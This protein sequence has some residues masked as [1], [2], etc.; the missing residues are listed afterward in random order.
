[1][2]STKHLIGYFSDLKAPKGVNLLTIDRTILEDSLT[3][4]KYFTN[5][6]ITTLRE[7]F[8]IIIQKKEQEDEQ[9]QE[10]EQE[11][12]DEDKE[13]EK[14]KF[15]ESK[16]KS[17]HKQEKQ[18]SLEIQNNYFQNEEGQEE[19]NKKIPLPNQLVIKLSIS[20]EER[21]NIITQ[22]TQQLYLYLTT[23]SISNSSFSV[24]KQ[25][26]IFL[27]KLLYL[28]NNSKNL[29]QFR[30]KFFGE[31]YQENVSIIEHVILVSKKLDPK[32]KRYQSRRQIKRFEQYLYY[33]EKLMLQA[34]SILMQLKKCINQ[35]NQNSQNN[36]VPDINIQGNSNRDQ[37]K[38]NKKKSEQEFEENIEIIN[39]Q[40]KNIKKYKYQGVLNQKRNFD[41]NG[42][43]SKSIKDHKILQSKKNY[44]KNV[45]L[46][47]EN[48]LSSSDSNSNKGSQYSSQRNKNSF[49]HGPR[50]FQKKIIENE[51]NSN[52]INEFEIDENEENERENDSE[53]SNNWNEYKYDNGNE[54]E[55]NSNSGNDTGIKRNENEN[56]NG[57]ENGNENE[58]KR[59][60]K[61]Y[62]QEKNNLIQMNNEEYHK[63]LSGKFEQEKNEEIEK[64][65]FDHD[66][67]QKNKV[68]SI[69]KKI[70]FES[71]KR[72][73]Q[74]QI[75][76]QSE[77][78]NNKSLQ[79]KILKLESQL[80]FSKSN[81]NEDQQN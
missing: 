7:S 53:N 50:S 77:I 31:N 37:Q 27:Q 65:K 10:Q 64:L 49:T 79:E 29:S 25:Q 40:E 11:Q 75:L 69:L 71:D 16:E 36:D 15:Q 58:K 42:G 38:I 68:Y 3:I 72:L 30:K 13:E 17:F 24:N 21:L 55:E 81:Q 5:S 34:K 4:L 32:K 63:I 28:V 8:G 54:N 46:E 44:L 66:F 47:L 6:I 12:E 26:E 74:I 14:D 59:I 19:T 18:N 78:Q 1:M 2:K 33:T 67:V 23:F 60:N 80:S 62:D 20:L 48:L 57:N 43:D 76:L 39:D 22:T 51:E 9:E 61:N 73:D 45:D 70:L 52:H 35:S 56:E 41:R